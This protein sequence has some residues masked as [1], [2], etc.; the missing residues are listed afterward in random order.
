M[1]RLMCFLLFSIPILS[2]LI[3][4]NY[5]ADPGNLFGAAPEK[6][7]GLFMEGKAHMLNREMWKK[8]R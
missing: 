3:F 8:E 6:M 4:V 7:V 2:L 1:K 5:N